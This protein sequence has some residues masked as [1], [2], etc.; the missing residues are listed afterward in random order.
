MTG[1]IKQLLRECDEAAARHWQLEARNR[2][3]GYKKWLEEVKKA[4][5]FIRL[6][7]KP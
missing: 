6:L 7:K 2:E 1:K 3:R 5:D 4:S